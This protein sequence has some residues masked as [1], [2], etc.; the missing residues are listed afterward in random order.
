MEFAIDLWIACVVFVCDAFFFPPLF[1]VGVLGF[2]LLKSDLLFCYKNYRL[3]A[4]V[5]GFDF[6]VD[7]RFII[8]RS[9]SS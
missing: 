5:F 8:V 1:L 4:S 7:S 9:L 3:I 6:D 2:R